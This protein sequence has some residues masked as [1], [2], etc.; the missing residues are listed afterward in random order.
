MLLILG[1]SLRRVL[2]VILC[3][4]AP[5]KS[6][7]IG[8]T[9]FR[10]LGGGT[11]SSLLD[12]EWFFSASCGAYSEVCRCPAASS[13]YHLELSYARMGCREQLRYSS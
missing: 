8:E 4:F 12:E 1:D 2:D 6:I 10:R 3:M 9:A 11:L 13:K 5:E 7:P